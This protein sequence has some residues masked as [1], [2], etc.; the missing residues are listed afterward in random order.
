LPLIYTNNMKRESVFKEISNEREYQIK[1]W[2]ENHDKENGVGDFL[3]T[4]ECLLQ[5]AKLAIGKGSYT[6]PALTA[7]RK[8]AAVAV[9]ALEK[10][11]CPPRV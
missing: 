3:V 9:A 5:D 1:K 2:G 4:V 7:L 6:L 11:G 8:A 10:Y